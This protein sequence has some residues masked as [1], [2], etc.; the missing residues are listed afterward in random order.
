MHHI[1]PCPAALAPNNSTS[2]SLS[3]QIKAHS[4]SCRLASYTGCSTS[5]HLKYW[6]LLYNFF[7]FALY[8]HQRLRKGLGRLGSW[9]QQ[10]SILYVRIHV[11]TWGRKLSPS[12]AFAP[13]NLR[14]SHH[15]RIAPSPH[16]QILK[17]SVLQ[18]GKCL[19]KSCDSPMRFTAVYRPAE[20]QRTA[21][22][23]ANGSK[24]IKVITYVSYLAF[25]CSL[26]GIMR[27]SG[28]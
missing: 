12:Y 20:P 5:L 10:A 6:I 18:D 19:G 7:F 21:Q 9:D 14:E 28:S 11:H 15:Q 16:P 17:I 22:A 25:Y 2:S 24:S 27:Y 26:A 1:S 23:W 13:N 8:T 3:T 4:P